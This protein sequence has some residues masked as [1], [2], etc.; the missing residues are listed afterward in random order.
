MSRTSSATLASFCGQQPILHG[1]GFG[2]LST[3]PTLIA[4]AIPEQPLLNF[5]FV[6]AEDHE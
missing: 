4:R 6:L 3:I 5:S 2:F 1:E